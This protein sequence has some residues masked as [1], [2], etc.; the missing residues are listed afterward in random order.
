MRIYS[1]TIKVLGLAPHELDLLMQ[2]VAEA[3]NGQTVHYSERETSPGQSFG[4][5]VSKEN[6]NHG[7][8]ERPID[9]RGIST[10][11]KL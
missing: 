3:K 9:D 10:K 4:I 11:R 7:R 2:M 1:K 5:S 8:P 6:E